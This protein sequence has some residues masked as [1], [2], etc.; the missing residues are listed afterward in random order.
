[1]RLFKILTTIVFS[2]LALPL[3]YC[4]NV[5]TFPVLGDLPSLTPNFA[6]NLVQE[7]MTILLD[8]FNDPQNSFSVMTNPNERNAFLDQVIYSLDNLSNSLSQ[9]KTMINFPTDSIIFDN[10]NTEIDSLLASMI[11][12]IENYLLTDE[13]FYYSY[14]GQF[15]D[16]L[17]QRFNSTIL[18][19]NLN[20]I[21]SSQ[22]TFYI[23]KINIDKFDL[24]T[25]QSTINSLPQFSESIQNIYPILQYK[26]SDINGTLIYLNTTLIISFIDTLQ[27]EGY[28]TFCG[29][30]NEVN[31]QW[32]EIPS[33]IGGN[34]INCTTPIKRSLSSTSGNNLDTISLFSRLDV[35]DDNN[36]ATLILATVIP[37]IF[38]IVSGVIGWRYYKRKGYQKF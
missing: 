25:I 33:S 8:L 9:I 20:K 19:D 26:I 6:L 22:I 24:T 34:I 29:M 30:Y 16:I 21:N 5:N 2:I 7:G 15:R 1:M 31:A 38:L 12:R 4:N 11:N 10:I 18:I 36:K 3:S 27:K 32:V 14:D 35:K 23:P 28:K 37:G 13:N 17:S